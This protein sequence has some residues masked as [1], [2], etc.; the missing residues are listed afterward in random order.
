MRLAYLYV[1]PSVAVLGWVPHAP[2]SSSWR[3]ENHVLHVLLPFAVVF[4]GSMTPQV[5]LHFPNLTFRAGVADWT[6][7]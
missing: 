6:G 7:E 2:K 1:E 3:A 5:Q 4:R